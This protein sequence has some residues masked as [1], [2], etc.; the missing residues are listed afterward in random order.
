MVGTGLGAGFCLYSDPVSNVDP[1]SNLDPV[2]DSDPVLNSD[3]VS[4]LDPVSKS[5]LLIW[6]L[7]WILIRIRNLFQIRKNYSGP[8]QAI[9]FRSWQYPLSNPS[10][11]PQPCL[12]RTKE[13]NSLN[14]TRSNIY[15]ICG[16]FYIKLFEHLPSDITTRSFWDNISIK[17]VGHKIVKRKNGK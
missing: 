13:R 8:D 6:I 1:V 12:N 7:S 10:T 9:K 4:N 17:C 15:L 2:M 16:C 11:Y 3:P 5:D 14:E